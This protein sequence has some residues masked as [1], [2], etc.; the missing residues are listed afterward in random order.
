MRRGSDTTTPASDY[1][2]RTSTAF[3]S[4]A[5]TAAK[6]G[7]MRSTSPTRRRSSVCFRA[8]PVSPAIHTLCRGRRRRRGGRL[9]GSPH[10]RVVEKEA[11]HVRHHQDT[12]AVDDGGL[13]RGRG[14]LCVGGE[15]EDSGRHQLCQRSAGVAPDGRATRP[16]RRAGG[17]RAAR[18][19]RPGARRTPS[20][21]QA[22]LG[23]ARRTRS[24]SVPS[25]CAILTSCCRHALASPRERPA[26][27]RP[28][29]PPAT[30]AF[31]RRRAPSR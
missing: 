31:P 15:R 22:S 9:L 7:P 13:C 29:S 30:A 25:A 4:P 26:L 17:A 2:R 19:R 14:A 16:S 11:R 23:A 24:P 20:S 6:P 27:Q 1:Q 5:T 21:R 12:D 3:L 18:A 28:S 10:G 8:A